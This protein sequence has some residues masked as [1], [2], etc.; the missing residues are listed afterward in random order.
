MVTRENV[1]NNFPH[2][3]DIVN[4]KNEINIK[5]FNKYLE[6]KISDN[7]FMDLIFN[8]FIS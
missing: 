5:L 4:S 2:Y 3:K 8:K 6:S 1:E 7:E